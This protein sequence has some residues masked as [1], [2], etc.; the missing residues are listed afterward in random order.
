MLLDF[1][2]THFC[3]VNCCTCIPISNSI[4]KCVL[5]LLFVSC[6]SFILGN[7]DDQTEIHF[8]NAGEELG[9]QMW[10]IDIVCIMYHIIKST[11]D[12][13]KLLYSKV[14]LINSE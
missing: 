2:C 13:Y 1:F 7:D 6:I 8:P 14:Y 10:R 12:Y 11:E 5:F 9:L 4:M 3:A